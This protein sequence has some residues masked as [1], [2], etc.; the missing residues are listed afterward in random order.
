MAISSGG[1]NAS[2]GT[3]AAA[4]LAA[5]TNDQDSPLNFIPEEWKKKTADFQKISYLASQ[6]SEIRSSTSSL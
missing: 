3:F 5:A 1:C 2:R 6:L 4:C